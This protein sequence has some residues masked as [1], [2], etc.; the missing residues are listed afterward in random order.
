MRRQERWKGRHS[1]KAGGCR[2]SAVYR[3]TTV[4]LGD[5]D[6][7]FQMHILKMYLLAQETFHSIQLSLHCLNSKSEVYTGSLNINSYKQKEVKFIGQR[8]VFLCYL[9]VQVRLVFVYIYVVERIHAEPC[10]EC[11]PIL[12][13]PFRYGRQ[14]Y[15]LLGKKKT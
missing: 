12:V 15:S 5:F 3:Y 7:H 13:W 6:E 11:K 8:T 9:P 4:I 10:V 1:C 14:S 2:F